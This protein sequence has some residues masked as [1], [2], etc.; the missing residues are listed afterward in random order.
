[1]RTYIDSNIFLYAVLYDDTRAKRCRK[2]V[3]SIFD[4]SIEAVTSTLTWDEFSHVVE[5]VAGREAAI[6][7]AERFL[8]FPRLSFEACTTAIL[9]QAQRLRSCTALG[10]RDSI[11]AATALAAKCRTFISEDGDFDGVP[12][13]KR[14]PA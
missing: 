6:P 4:G 13:L 5:R 8:R 14:R 3:E 10:A 12:G 9:V 11:H 7:E 2:I 1:M